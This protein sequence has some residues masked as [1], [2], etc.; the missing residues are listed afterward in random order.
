VT[1]VANYSL[2]VAE[3]NIQD[4]SKEA[5]PKSPPVEGTWDFDKT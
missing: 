2:L 1:D 4:D 3:K 5:S